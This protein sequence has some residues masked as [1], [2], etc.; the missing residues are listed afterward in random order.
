MGEYSS[1][2]VEK[3]LSESELSASLFSLDYIQ[4]EY[5]GTV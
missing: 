3:G 1:I 5:R 2:A 4:T